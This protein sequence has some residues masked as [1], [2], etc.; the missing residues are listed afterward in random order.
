MRLKQ[1][2][3]EN[4]EDCDWTEITTNQEKGEKK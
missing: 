1:W 4:Y 3:M 2:L